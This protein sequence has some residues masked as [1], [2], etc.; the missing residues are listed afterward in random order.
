[1]CDMGGAITIAGSDMEE[2]NMDLDLSIA[3]TFA[4]YIGRVCS[5]YHMQ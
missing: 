3:E 5:I 1:M 2:M 4:I